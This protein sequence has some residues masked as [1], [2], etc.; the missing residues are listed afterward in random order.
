MADETLRLFLERRERELDNQIA[1][2]KGTL[3]EREAELAEVRLAKSSLPAPVSMER[4]DLSTSL[5]ELPYKMAPS[6]DRIIDLGRLPTIKKMVR[7]SLKDK[8]PNGASSQLIREYLADVFRMTVQPD[9]L[10]AQLHRMKAQGLLVGSADE[11]SLT[12]AG[13]AYDGPGDDD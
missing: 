8:F 4:A 12:E 10:R 13:K 5:A 1:G 11:W 9:S 2:L 6:G 3:L 7:R